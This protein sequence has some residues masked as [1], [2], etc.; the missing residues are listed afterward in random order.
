MAVSHLQEPPSPACM[1]GLMGLYGC[2]VCAATAARPC[3]ESCMTVE[4]QCIEPQADSLDMLSGI[5]AEW[6]T[7]VGEL[8]EARSLPFS[9]ILVAIMEI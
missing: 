6:N 4:S 1:E 8:G 9:R 5:N 7:F 3:L 2:Q